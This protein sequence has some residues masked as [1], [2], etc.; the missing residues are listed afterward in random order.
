MNKRWV[1]AFGGLVFVAASMPAAVAQS[2]D[3]LSFGAG[4]PVPPGD[5]EMGQAMFDAVCWACH[6]ADLR[7][8]KGPPLTGPA[9]Y[10]TWQGR[11]VEALSD[12]IRNTMPKDNPGL[13]ERAARDV[14]AYIVAHANKPGNPAGG[15]AGK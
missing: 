15:Q 3:M 5:V 8:G 7:G 10:K 12:L 14:T 6:S 4:R 13:S 2:S 11:R 1:G 9:F